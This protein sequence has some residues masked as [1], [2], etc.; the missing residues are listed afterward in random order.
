VSAP[1]GAG[2]TTLCRRLLAER[3]DIAYS[4]SCTTRKPRGSEVDGV[5]YRFVTEPEF[6]HHVQAGDFLEHAVV[7]DHRYGTLRRAVVEALAAG[8]SVLMDIDVQGA[9]QIRKAIMESP[10][11]GPL[12]RG[13]VDIFIEPPSPEELRARLSGRHENSAQEMDRRLRNAAEEMRHA[14]EYMHRVVNGDLAA[15]YAQLA[16]LIEMEQRARADG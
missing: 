16:G 12:R 6:E 11:G 1:S 7:H 13:F 14:P 4:V 8:R 2:K 9:A 15:A 10:A 3:P 5:A